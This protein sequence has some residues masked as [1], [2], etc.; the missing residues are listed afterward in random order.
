MTSRI[1]LVIFCRYEIYIVDSFI[2]YAW[3]CVKIDTIMQAVD[4]M[5]NNQP[6]KALMLLKKYLP[7]ADDDKRFT[8]AE[9]YFQWGF[10]QESSQI[11]GDLIQR[12]PDENELKI[13]QANILIE[14]EEDS[15]AI[16]LLN[17]IE[18]DDPVYEQ[19][20]LLLADLY[21][22]QGLFEVSESKLLEAKQLNSDEPII[23]FALGELYFSIGDYKK[24][25]IYYEKVLSETR[26]M[27]QI[28][29]YERLAESYSATGEFEIA[30]NYFQKDDSD[31]PDILFK[32]G[33]T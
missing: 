32:F 1:E 30:L 19:A 25:I 33:L 4:Y 5:E 31:N 9:F 16:Q 24:A 14:L 7:T 13:L 2:S 20:L 27:G 23:D 6:E 10:F 12:Y 28:S 3:G 17:E 11:L 8:I 18:K 29:I 21:Q 26:I 15:E 22:I